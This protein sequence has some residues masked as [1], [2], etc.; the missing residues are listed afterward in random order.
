MMMKDSL[1]SKINKLSNQFDKGI[2]I[3]A[4]ELTDVYNE[5]YNKEEKVVNCATCLRT[6]LFELQKTAEQ[7]NR[8]TEEDK[9][10]IDW[11]MTLPSEHF[12]SFDKVTEIYNR[13]FK[14]N[15]VVNNCLPCL[16]KMIAELIK[17]RQL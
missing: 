16:K 7:Y 2:K 17:L 12:P 5:V 8:L 3:S 6:K 1:I 15:K 11:V 10:F 9:E 13:A 14:Q 4:K